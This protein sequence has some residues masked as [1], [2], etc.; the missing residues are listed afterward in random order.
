MINSME[1]SKDDMTLLTND[2]PWRIISVI[3]D[4]QL[5]RRRYYMKLGSGST[6]SV[7]RG[8]VSLQ[9]YMS[10]V[11]LLASG[12]LILLLQYFCIGVPPGFSET[13]EGALQEGAL[14]E[15]FSR[16]VSSIWNHVGLRYGLLADEAMPLF[17]ASVLLRVASVSMVSALLALAAGMF[18]VHRVRQILGTVDTGTPFVMANATRVRHV[19]L[20]LIASAVVRIIG[21][22]TVGLY[23]RSVVA[24]A[25]LKV[26]LR[27]NLRLEMIMAGLLVIV[28]SEVFRF[29]AELQEEQDLTV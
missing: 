23:I 6:L 17:D 14:A 15:E 5:E 26:D 25:G 20:A 3:T 2:K 29:G 11:V 4:D 8:L 18:A 1:L 19:G 12:I 7:A 24:A 22:L 10:W 13:V 9:W 28:L 27:T 21:D 16:F